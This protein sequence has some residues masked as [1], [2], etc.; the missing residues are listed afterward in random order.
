MAASENARHLGDFMLSTRYHLS[1]IV[2]IFFALGIGILLGGSL[3]QQWLSDRQQALVERLEKR[4]EEVQERSHQLEKRVGTLQSAVLEG[5]RQSRD[6]LRNAVKDQ[7]FGRRILLIGGERS[8]AESLSEVIRWAGGS[9][10]YASDLKEVPEDTDAILFL[11]GLTDSVWKSDVMRRVKAGLSAP[12]I[13]QV[14]KQKNRETSRS[15]GEVPV[16]PFVGELDDQPL[17]SYELIRMLHQ[18]ISGK[19]GPV[20]EV[21]TDG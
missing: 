16:Y 6:L 19:E 14:V 5:R 8:R 11:E 20:H 21:Q 9:V 2:A 13:V 1:T 3:G 17:D 12:V 10:S 15:L 18:S 7:L 4:Y